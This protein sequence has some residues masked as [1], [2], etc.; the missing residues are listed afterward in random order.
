VGKPSFHQFLGIVGVLMPLL[1]L[2]Q[3]FVVNYDNHTKQEGKILKN[4]QTKMT[5]AVMHSRHKTLV[6]NWTYIKDTIIKKS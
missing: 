3:S 2:I 4:K 1:V 6:D 5:D